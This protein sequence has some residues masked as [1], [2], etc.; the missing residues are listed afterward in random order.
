MVLLENFF[1]N[2]KRCRFIFFSLKL[3]NVSC[4]GKITVEFDN[5]CVNLK[6]LA[7]MVGNWMVDC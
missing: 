3:V 4:D 6:I 5:V 7:V 1:G 2:M